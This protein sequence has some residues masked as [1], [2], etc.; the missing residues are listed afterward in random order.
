MKKED[1]TER[2]KLIL[3]AEREIQLGKNVK[4]NQEKIELYMNS[5]RLSDL[6]AVMEE[7]ER[8]VDNNKNF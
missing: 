6:F 4:F 8:M 7:I 3:Q 2:A 1:I 5:L